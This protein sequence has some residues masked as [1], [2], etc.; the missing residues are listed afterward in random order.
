MNVLFFGDVVGQA[1]CERLRR[2][3]P[4]L[5]Q[6]CQAG[7]VVANGENSAEGNGIQIGRASC[8]ERVYVLV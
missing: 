5:K 1:G 3:L 4:R 8:R 6:V 2:E 7:V